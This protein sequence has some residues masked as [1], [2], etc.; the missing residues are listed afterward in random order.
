MSQLL[1]FCRPA[2]SSLQSTAQSQWLGQYRNSATCISAVKLIEQKLGRIVEVAE[3]LLY[4]N[5]KSAVHS[6]EPLAG[7]YRNFLTFILVDSHQ[8][9]N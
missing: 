4:S 3:I 9:E 2:T 6:T 1:K 5:I 8:H 7:E